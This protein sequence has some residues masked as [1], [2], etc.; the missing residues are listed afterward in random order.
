VADASVPILHD[1]P[2]DLLVN[3][4]QVPAPPVV[5]ATDPC[6]GAVSTDGLIRYYPFD[7]NEGG[8]LI[9][10]SGHGLTGHANGAMYTTHGYRG[11]A[12]AFTNHSYVD[13][14]HVSEVNGK[15]ALTWGA[16]IMPGG[17]GQGGIMGKS[18]PTNG[19]F[20]MTI[21]TSGRHL[22]ASVHA[23]NGEG[24]SVERNGLLAT[25]KWQHVMATY[26]GT[27]MRLYHDGLLV[28]SDAWTNS[29][30]TRTNSL[31]AAVGQVSTI[32]GPFFEGLIDEVRIY[33]RVLSDQEIYTLYR[34]VE[35]GTVTVQFAQTVTGDCPQAVVRTW[36]AADACGNAAR[37][38]QRITAVSPESDG[39]GLNDY[40]ELQ[41]GTDPYRADT[42]GDGRSDG[43]EVA[44]GTD[45]LDD[46][47]YPKY[48]QHDFDGDLKADVAYY[49]GASGTWH[50]ALSGTASSLVQQ[51]GYTG[52]VPVPGDYDGDGRADFGLYLPGWGNWFLLQSRAGFT[53]QQ[54]GFAGT[55]PVP[56]DYDG[57]GR[58]DIA[59]HDPAKSDWF[60]L[61]SKDGFTAFH[62]GSP[63]G[64]PLAADYD[65]DGKADPT[66]FKAGS[67][68]R[69]FQLLSSGQAITSTL[70]SVTA[71]PLPADFDGD[72]RADLA[73]FDTSNNRW[74]LRFSTTSGTVSFVFGLP[75]SVP[76]R[77]DYD[78]DGQS[79][80]G[81]YDAPGQRWIIG[82]SQDGLKMQT[83]GTPGIVPIGSQP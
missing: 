44:Q 54:F 11:G 17:G 81:V 3:C 70:G 76:V 12:F 51:F 10:A 74:T 43:L 82:Q 46:A 64:T 9:D 16:W 38:T 49:G 48:V 42:D 62:F 72:G 22:S 79:D 25:G 40:Q 33:Q 7:A 57:D 59:V 20:Q 73:I 37:A 34:G 53:G 63:M 18:Q 52:F 36:T 14:G 41:L 26:D 21:E 32:S 61:N 80:P 68:S 77:G 55:L 65:G 13:L 50:I 28:A 78:G 4:G 67:P 45:A 15:S 31:H 1:V 30:P 60:L 47:S 6:P 39:D 23:G 35:T 71:R 58:T 66:V 19:V 24:R 29:Q 69:W 83:F 2:P 5:T 56:A 27:T 8:S 75:G